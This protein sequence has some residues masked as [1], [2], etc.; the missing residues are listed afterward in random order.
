M[1]AALR[2]FRDVILI[3]I[4]SEQKERVTGK[5]ASGGM[6]LDRSSPDS[7]ARASAAIGPTDD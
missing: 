1:P 3:Q 2:H 6:A 5:V 4:D 7:L